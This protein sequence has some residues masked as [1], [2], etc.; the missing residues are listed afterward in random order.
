MPSYVAF[1]RGVSPMNAKMAELK[2]CF[3]SAGFTNVK[4]V[5]SSGNVVFDSRAAAET[6]LAR[7]IE[8]AMEKELERTF[9]TF[10]RSVD[11]LKALLDADP[12][13]EFRLPAGMKRIVT[14]LGEPPK[15]KLTLPLRVDEARILTIRGNEVLA[16]YTPTPGDPAFMRVLEKTFGKDITTRTWDTVKKC[17][18][19]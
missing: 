18:A 12:Y 2:A 13:D 16:A 8:K 4:T 19:A 1:L 15:S 7:R 14:F 3:E 6:S 17:A 5:L 9:L 10:V 11:A